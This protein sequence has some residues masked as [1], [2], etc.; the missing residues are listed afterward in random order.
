MKCNKCGV[1]MADG[2][3]FCS[4]C[5]TM[6]EDNATSVGSK[7]VAVKT[8]GGIMELVKKHWK[9][10][11]GVIIGLTIV[12]NLGGPTLDEKV[13]EK[14][15]IEILNENVLPS[16]SSYSMSLSDVKAD[17]VVSLDLDQK[18]K[19]WE[20]TAVVMFEK[21]NKSCTEKFNVTVTQKKDSEEC[22]VEIEFVNSE[23]AVENL[24]RL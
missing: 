5:G 12:A 1:E 4:K 13:V 19:I 24:R 6:L 11:V 7:D 2:E 8:G 21:G 18:G 15:I 23:D 9:T 3:K 16:L 14:T 22:L 17:E 20:G 10:I